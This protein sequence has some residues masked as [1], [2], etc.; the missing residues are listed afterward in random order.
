LLEGVVFEP[1][2]QEI[3]GSVVS[4]IAQGIDGGLLHFRIVFEEPLD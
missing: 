1:V 4:E 2:Q 3:Q